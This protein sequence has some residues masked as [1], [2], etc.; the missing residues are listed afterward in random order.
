MDAMNLESSKWRRSALEKDV[1]LDDDT[2]RRRRRNRIIV[3]AVGIVALIILAVAFLGGNKEKP[4]EVGPPM[5]QN[6]AQSQAQRVSVIVPGRSQVARTINSTGTI[7]A[8][9]DM[10][11]GVSGEGGMVSR[12]LVE[13]GQWVRAGQT[14][15]VIER[16]VQAQQAQQLA[17]SIQV[18]QAD[19]RLAQSELD[20]AMALV[21]RGFISKAD[22]DRKRATRDAANARVRVAQAQLGET[23]ARIGRL[24]VRAPTSGLVLSRSVEAGQVVSGGSGA[25]FRIADGGQMEVQARMVESDLVN[26]RVGSAATVT[27]V[28]TNL[29]IQGQVWQVSPVVDPASRQG[30]ARVA[31]PY[32]RDVRPGGFASVT[33]TSGTANLPLLPQSA[34][35]SDERGN[36]V[37]I[38]GSDNKVSRRNVTIGQ[39][40]DRGVSIAA[41]LSGSERV[42]ASA[43]A[44]LN[45]GDKIVPMREAA[46]S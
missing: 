37:Y 33:L 2:L 31:I 34:V 36:F 45:P 27:P 11:V 40:D 32:G 16:S 7:A 46:R 24:D 23:R 6:G 21:G 5:A 13:P 4:A 22:V 20:R 12:V 42:V 35:L 25:L 29:H 17:A 39:V 19:A 10:P 1:V 38:V 14:L 44:F 3:A 15:A 8:R 43:G 28:G 9:R 41:G 26:V 18:A 30:I